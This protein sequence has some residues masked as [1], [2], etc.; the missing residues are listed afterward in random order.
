MSAFNEEL[1]EHDLTEK[2]IQMNQK[3]K[4]YIQ[5]CDAT[6]A[7]EKDSTAHVAEGHM[8]KHSTILEDETDIKKYW[9]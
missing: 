5:N 2:I 6:D 3:M 8:E 7:A 9:W 1:F 4:N